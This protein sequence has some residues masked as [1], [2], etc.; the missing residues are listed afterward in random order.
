MT[1]PCPCPRRKSKERETEREVV[2]AGRQAGKHPESLLIH[3]RI[4]CLPDSDLGIPSHPILHTFPGSSPLPIKLSPGERLIR[5]T[6]A[7]S[8]PEDTFLWS[9][10]TKKTRYQFTCYFYTPLSRRRRRR[11]RKVAGSGA[12]GGRGHILQEGRDHFGSSLGIKTQTFQSNKNSVR[13]RP[14]TTTQ[15]INTY[16]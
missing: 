11:R 12:G 10:D 6:P 13:S 5:S 15:L 16:P 3:E 8:L 2:R 9:F 4:L 1:S 7:L 14:N